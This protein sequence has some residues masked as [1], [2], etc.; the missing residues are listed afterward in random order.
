MLNV[1]V[2]GIGNMGKN[3]VRTYSEIDKIK[4]VAISDVDEAKGKLLAEKHNCNFYKDYKDM[5]NSEKIDLVSIVV[6][7][8]FHEKVALDAIEKKINCAIGFPLYFGCDKQVETKC[9][10]G[11]IDYMKYLIWVIV[12]I[13]VI[14][15][16]KY[17]R[18]VIK[19]IPVIGK[20]IP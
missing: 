9:S 16:F 11:G 13:L 20:V 7:T 15:L 6:P 18:P 17:L 3:H 14:I 4:L 1:A 19:G 8:K 12:I 2:I 5:L 10:D